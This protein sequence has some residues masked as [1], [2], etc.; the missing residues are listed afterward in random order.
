MNDIEKMTQKSQAAMQAA[1]RE[2]EN[3]N[4]P[5]VEPEHL[6]FEI[7]R[8][9]DSIVSRVLESLN[10]SPQGVADEIGQLIKDFPKVSGSSVR[11][12]ASQR[13]QNLFK[14]AEKVSKSFGD[15][16]ISTEHFFLAG[17]K[18]PGD[19][20]RKLQA[21]G[22]S[23]STF[24]AELKRLRG[25]Q[26]VT[27]DNPEAKF[28]ALGKYGRD[29]T[30]LAERGKLD[31]VI[32]REEEIRRVIQVLS[33]RTKNNPVL[34]GEPGVGKT[35]IAEGLALR[36]I[37][38][39]VPDVLLGKK[40][41]ALDM[42]SLVAGAKYRGEFEDRLKAVVKEVTDSEGQIILFIDEMHTLV[43]A[44]KGEGSMDAGQILKPALAR[45]ELRCIG[46]T[47]LDE[48]RE[49]IE[50][51]K[52]LERRFQTVF[53]GEPS[54]SDAITILRGLK[55][56]YEVHHGVRITDA[57]IVAAVKLSH[58]Y[59]TN[60]FL[61]DKAIDLMDEAASRLSIEVNSVPS[62]VDE[63]ERRIK[64]MSVEKEALKKET[65]PSSVQR[66]E[67]IDKDLKSLES[68]A[69]DLRDKWEIEK[70][71]IVQLKDVKK[72]IE[73]TRVEMERAERE[74]RLE[75]AAELKYGRLPELEKKLKEF[76]EKAQTRTSR[77]LK[78]E[79]GPEEIASVVAKW[80][81][82]PIDKMMESESEKLLRMELFLQ[83][84]VKGQDRALE[85]VSDAIRRARAEISDPNRPIGSFIFLGP[86]GVGKTETAK[87]LAEFLFDTQDAMVRIDMSEYM[88]KHSVSR[89][90]GAPPG[91]V[92]FEEG[93]Q[94][95]ERIRRRPY[96]VILLDEIEKA[97]PDVFNVLLQVLDDGRLTDGQGRTVDFRNT[98]LIMTSNLGSHA[99]LDNSLKQEQKEEAVQQALR[100]HFR[101]EFL[102]RVDEVVLF[103]SLDE[104]QLQLIVE[105]QLE[106]VKRRLEEK[107]VHLDF[108]QSLIKA[109]AERGFD[110][111]FGARP[112]KRVIQ[113][114][115]LNAVA[116]KLLAKEIQPGDHL[117]VS[118]EDGKLSFKE[119]VVN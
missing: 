17:F 14:E 94:L 107:K 30:D 109:M 118:Y 74:G 38:Q 41:I 112:L 97:H 80:T 67:Q 49:Y 106:E 61:P 102:N 115:I 51:D 55:E 92:G 65:D 33:R 45:G 98:V 40:L 69:R 96:S 44:G 71:E 28:D 37:N 10:I 32:G 60:R 34:I 7:L 46:A 86:T 39:D 1:A 21:S 3:L 15:S 66:L 103:R 104:E 52:A 111:H 62:A 48:Y 27:D 70:N 75:K 79:V 101:P 76:N 84:R 36:I 89:L 20:S 119:P 57:A 6:L 108:D 31:P 83:N 117:L 8:Q 9:E 25:S 88:E 64:N 18:V 19:I 53:I 59:I 93:G 73:S 12:V 113:K 56:K 68:Q 29:L 13:L 105:N 99:L 82:I 85:V 87:A 23:S 91:Y 54:V 78:E 2:A 42:G 95:T 4:H 116:K 43:G 110:P 24:E 22:L 58:R 100:A 26:R 77:M 5:A 16:F 35:A 50:K 72:E 63:I 11:V 81:G 47:T 114:E 90:I